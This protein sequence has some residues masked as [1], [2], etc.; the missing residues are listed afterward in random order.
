MRTSKISRKTKETDIQLELNLDG[1]GIADISIGIGFWIIC[2]L[3]LRDMQNL[4]L[5][6]VPRAT[7][8]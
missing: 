2:L 7:F 1:T 4:T 8:T 3:P 6:S 5:R